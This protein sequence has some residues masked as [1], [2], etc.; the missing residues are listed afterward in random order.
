MI[1]NTEPWMEQ[2]RCREASGD[3][4][5]PDKG[6]GIERTTRMAKAICRDCP[7]AAAC[8]DYAM[9]VDDPFGIYAGTTPTDRQ[10]LRRG[11]AA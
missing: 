4:W 2:G 9:R 3:F 10:R 1:A 5:F 11:A 8:L 6:Q 7:V